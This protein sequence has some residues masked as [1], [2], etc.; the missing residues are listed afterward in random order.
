[1]LVCPGKDL[2]A[3]LDDGLLSVQADEFGPQVLVLVSTFD[4]SFLIPTS[5]VGCWLK[6][7]LKNAVDFNLKKIAIARL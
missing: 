5:A 2:I 3:D 4:T 7:V 6:Q 1:M